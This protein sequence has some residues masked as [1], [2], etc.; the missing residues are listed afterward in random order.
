[1][2]EI[3]TLARPY[4]KAVFEQASAQDRLSDWSDML[5]LLAGVIGNEDMRL[6]IGNPQLSGPQLVDLITGVCGDRLDDE[7]CNLVR[8]LAEKHRLELLPAIATLYEE[9]RAEAERRMEV[10][11]YSAVELPQDRRDAL[12]KALESRLNRDVELDCRTD[13]ELMGGVLIRAGDLIID[14]SVREQLHQ[15]MRSINR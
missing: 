4:A 11:V 15:L 1:M 2:A 10:Q 6:L 13:P 8:L 9:R 5:A 12:A 3:N 7:A 14:R